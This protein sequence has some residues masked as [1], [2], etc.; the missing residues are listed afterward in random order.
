VVLGEPEAA[1]APELD[2]LREIAR[3]FKG[4]SGVA[5]LNDRRQ[6]EN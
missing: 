3:A 6:I 4:L 5:A 2:V 1:I